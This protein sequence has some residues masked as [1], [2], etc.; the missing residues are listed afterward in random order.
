[1]R[2]NQ[3]SSLN[4]LWLSFILRSA[5]LFAAMIVAAQTRGTVITDVGYFTRRPHTLITFEQRG[6]GSPTPTANATPLP[7]NEYIT[8]GVTFSPGLSS[9]VA[10]IN[11]PSVSVDA[12]QIVGGSLQLAIGAT[13]NQGDFFINFMPRPVKAF[14]F[15]VQHTNERSGI[16]TFDAIG[17]SGILESAFFRGSVIDGTFGNIDYGFLGLAGAAPIRAIHVRGDVALLDNFRFI[18][19]PEPTGLNYCWCGG[20]AIGLLALRR[21]R[22]S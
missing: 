20:L 3:M 2:N 6:D 13:D 9:G 16:P 17:A 12:G 7:P 22:Y 1:M 14:G 5:T 18:A 15:W 8:W 21:N 19:I 10:W 4:R 11:D